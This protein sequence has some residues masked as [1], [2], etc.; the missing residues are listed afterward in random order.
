[1]KWYE[2]IGFVGSLVSILGAV[3]TYRY[4]TI[5]SRTKDE[6]FS[7]FKVLKFSNISESSTTT[8]EQI[9]K[10]AHKQKIIRGT[11]VDDIVNSLNNYYEKVFKLSNEVEV[12][13]SE[14]IAGFITDYREKINIIGNTPR[15]NET[16]LIT[17]FN[18]IYE[19]TLNINQEFNKFTKNIVEKK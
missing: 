14:K 10:I 2:I 18:E 11:N 5:I 1:M 4:S 8:I 13:K 17:H 15:A 6:I 7:L 9:K 3:Y 19:L 12:E 16:A